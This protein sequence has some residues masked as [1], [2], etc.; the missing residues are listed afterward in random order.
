[1]TQYHQHLRTHPRDSY[2]GKLTTKYVKSQLLKNALGRKK[3][4]N[5]D[6]R[7]Q[8]IQYGR[9]GEGFPKMPVA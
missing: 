6:P 2:L 3:E 5:V 7:K 1:M 4:E 8:E 9:K